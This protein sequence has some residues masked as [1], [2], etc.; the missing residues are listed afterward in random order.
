MWQ[1]YWNWFTSAF[2][3]AWAISQVLAGVITL[4][5]GILVWKYPNWE[6]SAKN[7]LWMIPLGIFLVLLVIRLAIAPFNIYQKQQMDL[8]SIEKKLQETEKNLEDARKQISLSITE[9]IASLY[10]KN[11]DIPLAS[12]GMINP[13]IHDKVFDH[14]RIIGPAVIA[15]P[16]DGE[17]G[18]CTFQG[19]IN[20]VFITTTNERITGIIVLKNCKFLSCDFRNVSFIGP[21]DQ[22]ARLKAGFNLPSK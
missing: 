10:I 15:A 2:S 13:I 5:M 22:I 12:L 9:I 7:L 14:C 1:F 21:A 4:I 6:A 3:G 17:I 8:R 18:F 20:S 16:H 19:D 11:R